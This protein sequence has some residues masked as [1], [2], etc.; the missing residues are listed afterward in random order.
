MYNKK[1]NKK[2]VTPQPINEI[3]LLKSTSPYRANRILQL[4][5]DKELHE[6]SLL[7]TT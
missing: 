7:V 1:Y 6:I 5:Q 3:C 2:I 4:T